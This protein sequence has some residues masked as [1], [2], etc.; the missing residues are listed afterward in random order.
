MPALIKI[1]TIYKQ[2]KSSCPNTAP[3]FIP[4]HPSH[5]I[6]TFTPSGRMRPALR[7]ANREGPGR[8]VLFCIA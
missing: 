7:K 2:A 1:K 5:K 6:P 4:T 3:P 8:R